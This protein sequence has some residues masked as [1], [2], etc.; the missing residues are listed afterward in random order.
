MSVCKK[1]GKPQ[2]EHCVFEAK[3]MP[4]GCVCGVRT[5]GDTVK[6]ICAKYA[7]DGNENCYQ[8]EHDKACHRK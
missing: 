7:G 8:C 5:W 6:P 3:S 2:S 1:C 4:E